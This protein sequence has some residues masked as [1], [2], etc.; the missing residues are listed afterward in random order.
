MARTVDL[1]M[2]QGVFE[3]IAVNRY[4]D[5]DIFE[6]MRGKERMFRIVLPD[7]TKAPCHGHANLE[8]LHRGEQETILGFLSDGLDFVIIDDG[9]GAGY[10]RKHTIPYINALLCPKLLYF[11]QKIDEESCG[12]KFDHLIQIGRYTPAIIEFARNCEKADL[13]FFID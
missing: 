4:P 10:C 12:R 11:S 8:R 7:V 9:K 2:T 3:E 1:C 5:A 13:A 6:Q